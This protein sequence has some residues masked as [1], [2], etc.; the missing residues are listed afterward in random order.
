MTERPVPVPVPG[1]GPSSSPVPACTLL[2]DGSCPLCA[3]EVAL[4]R[5][6][7]PEDGR[8]GFL[9]VSA[10]DGRPLP[11]GIDRRRAMARLH[12][13]TADGRVETG[14]RAM[15]TLWQQ[16]PGFRVAARL[17]RIPPLPWLLE[18]GYRGFLVVRPQLQWLARGGRSLRPAARTPPPQ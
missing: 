8:V 4:Y 7:A 15:L 17:L 9:D 14:A 12:L 13:I 18:I 10:E 3:R 2:H 16:L 11:A 6:L 5:R 1:P